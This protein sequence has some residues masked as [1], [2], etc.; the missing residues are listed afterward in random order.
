MSAEPTFA[1]KSVRVPIYDSRFTIYRSAADLIGLKLG[2]IVGKL[3]NA[4]IT[5]R[6]IWFLFRR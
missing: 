4:G 1:D 3:K 6:R 5:G 2:R